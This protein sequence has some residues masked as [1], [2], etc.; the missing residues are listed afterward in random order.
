MA[1]FLLK[2][3]DKRAGKYVLYQTARA[4]G[5]AEDGWEQIGHQMAERLKEGRYRDNAELYDAIDY[6]RKVDQ[7][8]N[9]KSDFEAVWKSDPELPT[10]DWPIHL[11]QNVQ[12]IT[13]E[14]VHK[15]HAERSEDYFERMLQDDKGFAE[16]VIE[17]RLYELVGTISCIHTKDF[18]AILDELFYEEVAMGDE[19]IH[20]RFAA[21]MLRIGDLLDMDNN[22]F[23]LR[24]LEHRGPLPPKSAAHL[25]KHKALKN[26]EITETAIRAV[27]CSGDFMTCLETRT[28]YNWIES[29]VAQ[30]IQSWN[31]IAPRH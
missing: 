20:P 19:H 3:E 6:Y 12:Y 16:G 11:I 8:L 1:L 23:N 22:R 10:A 5:Y 2:R 31:Q 7:I 25:H 17:K 24:V 29:E 9:K 27:A 30:L 21:A 28:W 4:A 15:H 14:Y 18:D 26:F 13:T